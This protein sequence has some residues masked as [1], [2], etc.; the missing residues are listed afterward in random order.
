V[1]YRRLPDEPWNNGWRDVPFL[2]GPLNPAPGGLEVR[3]HVPLDSEGRVPELLGR[4]ELEELYIHGWPHGLN[5][6][7]YI[8]SDEKGAY[9]FDEQPTGD[10]PW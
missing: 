8:W 4:D 6:T 10:G 9:Q 7:G 1:S 5:A 3:Y 2:D